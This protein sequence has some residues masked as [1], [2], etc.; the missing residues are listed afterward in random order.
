MKMLAVAKEKAKKTIENRSR[1]GKLQMLP[2]PKL[3]IHPSQLP[4]LATSRYFTNVENQR[5][6]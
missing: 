5:I 2:K 6:F 1:G 3:K 4:I